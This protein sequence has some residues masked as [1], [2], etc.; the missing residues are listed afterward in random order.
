MIDERII[1]TPGGRVLQ[2]VDLSLVNMHER[3][4]GVVASDI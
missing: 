4:L 2:R 3:N 1:V